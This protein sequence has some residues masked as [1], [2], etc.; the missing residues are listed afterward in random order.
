MK[1]RLKS[2]DIVVRNYAGHATN[3]RWFLYQQALA[4]SLFHKFR[5]VILGYAHVDTLAL[6]Q[7]P[8][9]KEHIGKDETK[10][11]GQSDNGTVDP[12]GDHDGISTTLDVDDEKLDEPQT[13]VACWADAICRTKV[14]S[15]PSA[16][17]KKHKLAYE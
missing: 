3:D 8:P 15:R 5:N 16:I 13:V 17:E 9:I 4:R 1:D 7:H 2:E 11:T 14:A 12:S 10:D 6:D